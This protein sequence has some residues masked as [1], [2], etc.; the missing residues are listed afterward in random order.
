MLKMEVSTKG[1]LFRSQ[2][3]IVDFEVAIHQ[4][5]NDVWSNVSISGCKFHLYQNWYRNIQNVV[6]AKEYE[7]NTESSQYLK[8][9]FG[10]PYLKPEDVG[11]F[12]P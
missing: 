3:I 9:F 8:L 5:I 1:N 7:N 2:K 11:D 12:L 10:L 6:F 4:A